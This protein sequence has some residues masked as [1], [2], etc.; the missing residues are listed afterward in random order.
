M[1]SRKKHKLHQAVRN[2][3]CLDAEPSYRNKT[4]V[5]SES[6]ENANNKSNAGGIMRNIANKLQCLADLSVF[7]IFATLSRINA[8]AIAYKA[9]VYEHSSK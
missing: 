1:L 3:D 5:N 7:R 9:T 4:S 8:H 6:C 2:L